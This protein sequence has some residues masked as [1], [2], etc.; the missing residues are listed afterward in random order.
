MARSQ[1]I[2]VIADGFMVVRMFT[3]KHEAVRWLKDAR[4][5]LADRRRPCPYE[6]YRCAHEGGHGVRSDGAVWHRRHKVE[7][8]E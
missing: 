7:V 6:L 1:A 8:P 2:F 4:V 5:I 3:V